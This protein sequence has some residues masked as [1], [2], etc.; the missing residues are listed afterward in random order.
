MSNDVKQ[1]F[2]GDAVSQ[3]AE[4][5]QNAIKGEIFGIRSVDGGVSGIMVPNTHTFKDLTKDID[6]RDE[7]LAPGP[8]RLKAREEAET[9]EGFVALV[10]R[11]GGSNTAIEALVNPSP[12]MLAYVDYHVQSN[13]E[14]PEA[15]RLEHSISYA[16]PYSSRFQ[17]WHNASKVWLPKRAFLAFVQDRVADIVSPHEVEAAKDSVTRIEFEGVLR[18]RGKTQEE[19]EAAALETLFGTPENLA[20]GA[21]AMGAISSEEYDEVEAGL[22]EVTVSYKKSDRTTNSEKVREF[23]LVE[24]AVFEGDKPQVLPAR[25]RVKVENG[26]LY[27]CLELLGLRTVIERSFAAACE[28]V[29]SETTRPVYRCKLA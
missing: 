6:E 21:K 14:G 24:V 12:K 19:R 3:I 11:H 17:M 26:A 29:A 4:L 25:L 28:R 7:R 22:G 18:A 5:A 27:L 13:G 16:F 10:Q 8:R 23:Y 2:N 20:A 1:E 15:R 9:L